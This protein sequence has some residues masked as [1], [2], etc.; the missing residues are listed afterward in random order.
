M[1]S[2]LGEA[3]ELFDARNITWIKGYTGPPGPRGPPGIP[4]R[5]G[6]DGKKINLYFVLKQ[7]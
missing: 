6:S 2:N 7:K 3:G 4:G 1:I 5:P